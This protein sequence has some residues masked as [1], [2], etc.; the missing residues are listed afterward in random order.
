MSVVTLPNVIV[1]GD[2]SDA[3]KAMAN[4]IACVNGF[5]NIDSTNIDPTKALLNATTHGNLYSSTSTLHSAK[6]VLLANAATPA[7]F[8]AGANVEV[9]LDEIGS[10]L[11]LVNGVGAGGSSFLNMIGYSSSN[12]LANVSVVVPANTATNSIIVLWGLYM[13][14]EGA[15]SAYRVSLSIE[16]A[17]GGFVDLYVSGDTDAPP[18]NVFGIKCV[19]NFAVGGNAGG[20]FSKLSVI[21]NT[22]LGGNTH[23]GSID[24][25]K[26]HTLTFGTPW[27]TGGGAGGHTAGEGWMMVFVN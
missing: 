18:Y 22:S 16:E 13:L 21:N 8:T 17:T 3:S 5:T 19:N 6:S 26:E 7:K 27:L 20:N 12:T 23:L 9:A 1:N 10:M 14:G 11:K 4:W 24:F 2:Q 25:T 15:A